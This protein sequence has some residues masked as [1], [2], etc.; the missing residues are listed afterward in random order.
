MSQQIAQ[1]QAKSHLERIN[2]FLTKPHMV[3]GGLAVQQYV[4]G[5][6]SV[7]ID[8]ICDS[9]TAHGIIAALFPLDKYVTVDENDDEYRPAFVIS[10]RNT[11]EAIVLVGP[12]IL[13][14]EAYQHLTWPILEENSRNFTVKKN[15]LENIRIPS[16]EALAY[17]KLLSCSTRLETKFAKGQADLT[18]FVNLTNVPEFNLN[19]FVDI[20]RNSR[21][22]E[23]LQRRFKKL[24][25]KLDEAILTRSPLFFGGVLFSGGETD[26]LPNADGIA[27]STVFEVDAAPEFYDRISHLYDVRNSNFLYAAHQ[28]IVSALRDILRQYSEPHVL[29]I[30]AGTG[31]LI[32]THFSHRENLRWVAV[33]ASPKMTDLFKMNMSLGRMPFLSICCDANDVGLKLKD[34][35][36]V[37]VYI[38]AFVLTSLDSLDALEKLIENAKPGSEFIIADIH[39]EYTNNNPYYHFV[40][41]DGARVALKPKPV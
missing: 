37:D 17:T 15:E 11:G 25:G 27:D 1:A 32:A 12:K 26:T 39:P 3:I 16:P 18:D 4:V 5:R 35:D 8:L 20:V 30:G 21:G 31:R 36:Q 29:D 24:E 22:V 33:D 19:R 41:S 7:D 10:P 23:T 34:P 28:K 40:E 13:E 9:N 6:Q 38:F 2:E 14:R